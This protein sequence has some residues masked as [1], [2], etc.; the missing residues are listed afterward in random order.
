[1][2]KIELN[3]ILPLAIDVFSNV[4][5]KEYHDIISKKINNSIIFQYIDI[6]GYEDYLQYVKRCKRRELSYEFLVKSRLYNG[7]IHNF[8]NQFSEE[9]RTIL[10]SFI[11]NEHTVFDKQLSYYFAPIF[12]FDENNH[13]DS[14]KLMENKLKIINYFRKDNSPITK[15]NFDDFVKTTDYQR[16]I[17]RINI[18][19]NIY[20]NL[21]SKYNEFEKELEPYKNY[22]KNEKDSYNE[23][24][25][26]KK[27]E[28]FNDIFP[29]INDHIIYCIKDM[30]LTL[31]EDI[32]VGTRDLSEKSPLEYFS[33]EDIQL[34]KSKDCPVDEKYW[35]IFFQSNYLK[36]F[37]INID[38]NLLSF[39][40]EEAIEKYLNFIFSDDIKNFIPTQ[41]TICKLYTIRNVKYSEAITKY[42]TQRE[43]FMYNINHF[44]DN[45]YN[46]LFLLNQ[47]LNND[48]CV[49][50]CGGRNTNS[51][52]LSLMFFTIKKDYAGK[53]LHCF[54]HELGHII[55]QNELGCGFESSNHLYNHNLRNPYDKSYRKYERFNEILTD[56]YTME[57]VDILHT[58][59][60]YLIEDRNIISEDCKNFNTS[61]YLKVLLMPLVENYKFYISKSKILSDPNYLIEAIGLHNFESLIDSINK[62]DF[63][64]KNGLFNN[65]VN[66]DYL[67]QYY[68]ETDCIEKIYS[69]IKIYHDSIKHLLKKHL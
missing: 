39:E 65:N 21:L 23:I 20:K 28:F 37:G 62:I 30:N 53:L 68:A 14:D 12:A 55:D 4:Y 24:M 46:R 2:F 34:L 27:I 41:E 16:I 49:L 8:S 66:E 57:A 6:I 50:S 42:Y 52:F 10:D 7:I 56:I 44:V 48:I 17:K 43:D 63:L 36:N 67:A 9:I 1:M 61:A 18:Y 29:Y 51:E 26:E 22:I 38:D 11:G 19:K 5:G 45:D 3:E 64:I 32:I 31:Q 40:N 60:I 54:M 59:N 15:T 33:E 25:Y 58:N 47:I 13:I 69:E 35:I